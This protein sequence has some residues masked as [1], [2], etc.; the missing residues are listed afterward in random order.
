V[1]SQLQGRASE[2]FE[3]IEGDDEQTGAGRLQAR[4][5]EVKVVK[6]KGDS[7]G[8]GDK[9]KSR[10]RDRR[11]ES[12]VPSPSGALGPQ[13]AVSRLR[14]GD[15]DEESISTLCERAR[16]LFESEQDYDGAEALYK[17]VLSVDPN[18]VDTLCNY[19]LLLETTQVANRDCLSSLCCQK[20][21]LLLSP[22]GCPC[23]GPGRR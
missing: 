9:P 21:F 12:R 8:V 5:E 16:H 14:G 19:A 10:K 3:Q 4:D 20:C 13:D 6:G 1:R 15:G 11:K 17:R 22:A 23:A 2:W 7:G 18:H